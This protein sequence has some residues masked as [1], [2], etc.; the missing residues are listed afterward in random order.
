MF[1]VD[2]MFDDDGVGVCR[3]L[4]YSRKVQLVR[5]APVTYCT[6]TCASHSYPVAAGSG[7]ERST[8]GANRKQ[9]V[10]WK[11]REE[12]VALVPDGDTWRYR[13][14]APAGVKYTKVP[15]QG[16]RAHSL[17]HIIA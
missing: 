6:C 4:G 2:N 10:H 16:V 17:F 7:Y 9:A 1:F 11:A 3:G 15:L 5:A 8:F 12:S 14:Q 13:K